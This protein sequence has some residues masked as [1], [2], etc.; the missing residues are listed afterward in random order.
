M[1]SISRYVAFAAFGIGLAICGATE[2]IAAKLKTNLDLVEMKCGSAALERLDEKANLT[3]ME[4]CNSQTPNLVSDTLIAPI[5][6][7]LA[8]R[9]KGPKLRDKVDH[10]RAACP[11]AKT[12]LDVLAAKRRKGPKGDGESGCTDSNPTP[13]VPALKR[14]GPKGRSGSDAQG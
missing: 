8:A 3:R 4:E 2:L 10:Q 11:P 12:V 13:D 6:T 9:S 1:S 5:P 7:I 14:K